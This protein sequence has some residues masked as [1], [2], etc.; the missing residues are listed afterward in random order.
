MEKEEAL[1]GIRVALTGLGCVELSCN[2]SNND[3]SP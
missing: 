3:E 1:N 2:N